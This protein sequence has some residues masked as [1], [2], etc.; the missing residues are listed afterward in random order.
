MGC[1]CQDPNCQPCGS[2]DCENCAPPPEPILP[3]CDVTL[4]DG[5]YPNATVVVSEGCIIQVTGGSNR[6]YSP[7]IECCGPGGGGGGGGG[8]DPGG[9]GGGVCDCEDGR[10]ATITFE[11]V[12]LEDPGTNPSVTAY[13]GPFETHLQFH[14]PK[15]W[16][17]PDD[18]G[19][20]PIGLTIDEGDIQIEDGLIT[21]VPSIWPPVMSLVAVSVDIDISL[22][23]E[24]SYVAGDPTGIWTITLDTTNFLNRIRNSW[25]S[26]IA[27]AVS[28]ATTPLEQD[29]VDLRNDVADLQSRVTALENA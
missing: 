24:E 9:G 16:P 6:V 18:P 11:G 8:G 10:D 5:V 17:D 4:P 25:A 14:L 29:I 19:N 2:G 27:T 26:A 22:T 1:N 23:V 7:T 21:G 28:D 3:K 15:P 20:T 12:V 13:G